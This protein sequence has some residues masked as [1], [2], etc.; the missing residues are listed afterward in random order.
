MLKIDFYYYSE[1]MASGGKRYLEL[2][3]RIKTRETLLEMKR[4]ASELTAN[5]GQTLDQYDVFFKSNG[6]LYLRLIQSLNQSSKQLVYYEA[7]NTI[8]PKVY[9]YKCVPLSANDAVTMEAILTQSNGYLCKLHRFR[10]MYFER[11]TDTHIYL[12]YIHDLGY[13]IEFEISL[14]PHQFNEYGEELASKLLKTFKLHPSELISYSEF[15][16]I[17][18][19]LAVVKPGK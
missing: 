8:G 12:D 1:K 11:S 4:I 19:R 9:I 17:L 13:F 18:N 3:A 16:E 14:K 5:D 6:R 15:D 10:E 7:S 2:K